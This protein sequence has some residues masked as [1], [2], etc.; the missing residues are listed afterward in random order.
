MLKKFINGFCMALAD[1]VPGVSGGTVAFILGFY[2][3]FIGSI[4]N[5]L[6]ERK[7]KQKQALYYL[8]KLGIG[9]VT[10]MLIA[11]TILSSAF[12]NHIYFV[13]S[14][15]IG[16]VTASIPYIVW[17]EKTAIKDHYGNIVFAVIGA[18]IVI[19]ITYF[20]QS[21]LLTGIQL[22]QFSV[23]LAIYVFVAG[24]IAI[25]AMFLPGISGS[26]LLLIFGLYL[27][28]I[29]GIKSLLHLQLAYFPMLCIFGFGVIV[30][31]A[32]VVKGIRYCLLTYRSQTMY[33]ILGLMI[34]SLYAI[35]MGPATLDVPAK[36]VSFAS[37]QWIAFI[38][39]I[40]VV[41]FLQLAGNKKQMK[42]G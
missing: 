8:C 3:D 21:S 35:V 7:E 38:L 26:T 9:W 19:G 20:N 18:I 37:F 34:G 36:P 40:A 15:F 30:G 2:D 25:S 24:M 31:A 32:S 6:F 41:I 11:V 5:L 39:G 22:N 28:V 27:P 14:L 13:S 33:M 23:P 17:Q 29:S 16:F 12:E 1:S 4:H 10:G 42:E